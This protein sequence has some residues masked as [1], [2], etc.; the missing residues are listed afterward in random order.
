MDESIIKEDNPII[1]VKQLKSILGSGIENCICKIITLTKTGTGFFVNI[2]EKNIKVLITNNHIIDEEFLEKENK[3]IYFISENQNEINLEINRYIL[4]DKELDFTIIEILE[5]DNINNYLEINKDIYNKNDKIYTFQYPGEGEL[6]YSHGEILEIKDNNIIYDIGTLGGSSGC[7]IILM[8]NSKLIGLHI[9]YL[10][11][12]KIKTN[13]G[14]SINYIINKILFIKCTYEIND[15]N[16]YIQIIND[17]DKYN[18]NK[19][20]EFKIRILNK[21][22]KEKIVYKIFKTK[23]INHIFF[24]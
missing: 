2:P 3:I 6:E 17:N 1:D 20:I 9:G 11:K 21:G 14:I 7:P 10:N 23:G 5:E 13:I 4:T 16:N 24:M 19:E 8:N 22:K 12:R 18:I 15:I